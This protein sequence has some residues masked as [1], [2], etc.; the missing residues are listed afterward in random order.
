MEYN[1]LKM[2]AELRPPCECARSRVRDAEAEGAPQASGAEFSGYDVPSQSHSIG[3]GSI[4]WDI[5]L[6]RY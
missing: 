5:F 4:A 1:A 3:P 2:I 6:L